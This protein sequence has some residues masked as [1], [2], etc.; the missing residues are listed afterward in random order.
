MD[1]LGDCVT[2]FP[3]LMSE[4]PAILFFFPLPPPPFSPPFP[5]HQYDGREGKRKKEIGQ[6]GLCIRLMYKSTVPRT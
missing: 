1:I 3:G 6:A 2:T 4:V 5:L